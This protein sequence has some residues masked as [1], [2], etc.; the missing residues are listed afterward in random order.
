MKVLP[1]TQADFC[2]GKYYTKSIS[3]A[4][5]NAS[6]TEL[7]S[8]YYPVNFKAKTIN[9]QAEKTKLIKQFNEILRRD[10]PN[11]S[12][13]EIIAKMINT[14]AKFMEQKHK[15]LET[16]ISQTKIIRE[17]KILTDIQKQES[18]NKLRKDYIRIQKS[19]PSKPE[20]TEEEDYTD[21]LLINKFKSA[22]LND[23]LNLKKVFL[24]HYEPL[25][26]IKTIEELN[27]QFPSIDTPLRPEFVTAKKIA[28]N[29]T[30][31]FFITLDEFH[32]KGDTEGVNNY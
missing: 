17:S 18:L 21:F 11:P 20:I 15:K 13:E 29:L 2:A 16:V 30:K 26:N 10:T 31:E 1:I 25:N 8:A 4:V 9:V 5:C 23:N 3:N 32:Q 22:I 28:Q 19:F 7:S 12:Y 6:I 24:K 27:E 14:I